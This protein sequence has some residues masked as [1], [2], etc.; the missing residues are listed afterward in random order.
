MIGPRGNSTRLGGT[1]SI[2]LDVATLCKLPS[3]VMVATL[4]AASTTNTDK[5][6]GNTMQYYAV[7][8][9]RRIFAAVK[10][11]TATKNSR[12]FLNFAGAFRGTV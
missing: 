12:V 7:L 4:A 5:Y 11:S 10:S 6:C 3:E 8:L 9:S 1:F 2:Q